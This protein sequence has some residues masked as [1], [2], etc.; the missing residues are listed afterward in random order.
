MVATSVNALLTSY[1]GLLTAVGAPR[2]TAR[3]R[4][5]QPATRF[6]IL[7]PAHNEEAVISDSLR[8]FAEIDYPTDLFDVHVVAD[9]CSDRTA[10]IAR[11]HGVHVH[12][13]HAPDQP[14]KGPA[15]NWLFDIVDRG[16][17]FDVALVV[18]ADTIIDRDFLRAMD[19]AFVRGA[20][21]AQGFYSVRDPAGSTSAGLRYAA[22]ACRHHLRPQGRCRLGA[23]CGLYGN[24]MAFRRE[25][26]RRRRWTGHLVEDAE[27]QMEL[28]VRDGDIATYVPQ[29]LI[30]AEMPGTLEAASSQN[31][32]WERGRIELARRYLPILTRQFVHAPRHRRIA[33]A[34]A[35]ADH[36]VPPLSVM[37]TAQLVTT[38][39]NRLSIPLGVPRSRGRAKV[40]AMALVVLGVH[41]VAGLRSVSAPWSVYR[42]LTRAPVMVLWKVGLWRRVLRR[43]TEVE[44]QRTP[45]NAER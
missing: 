8:S 45:R 16:G 24:G 21:A 2:P 9:N 30:H 4:G 5:L 42:S 41:V 40:D 44:W 28:L 32:R 26:L 14:G 3:A 17:E 11:A 20:V 34:D 43:R 10:D 35:I 25:V 23:S 7:V 36:L 12:E 18:D 39:A 29:A 13:R 1:L 6:V 22:L 37:V 27:F 38:I 15:L 19:T 33:I 31:E